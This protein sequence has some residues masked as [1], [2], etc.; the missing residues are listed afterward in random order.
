MTGYC[1]VASPSRRSTRVR[2]H[3]SSLSSN[4][5]QV[6]GMDVDG[7]AMRSLRSHG[8]VP[9]SRGNSRGP[10]APHVREANTHLTHSV[11]R[12]RAGSG[13]LTRVRTYRGRPTGAN[14]PPPCSGSSEAVACEHGQSRQVGI[15][16][17]ANYFTEDFDDRP[18]CLLPENGTMGSCVRLPGW[19]QT[20]DGVFRA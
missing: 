3:R 9:S 5:Q 18:R 19:A 14:S 2:G 11:S 17:V 20:Q 6:V 13:R 10:L 7:H 12:L 15:F 16:A 1:Q 8:L 4:F